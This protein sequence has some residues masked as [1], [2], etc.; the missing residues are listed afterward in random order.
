MSS[1]LAMTTPAGRC[2][3]GRPSSWRPVYTNYAGDLEALYPKTVPS[4]L[5][6]FREREENVKADV[7]AAF[8]AL[9]QQVG[10]N[11]MARIPGT[12]H[13]SDGP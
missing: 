13:V 2:A 12:Y 5:S 8:I 9:L 7:F 11:K 10:L 4:L 6:R 3:A 1:T